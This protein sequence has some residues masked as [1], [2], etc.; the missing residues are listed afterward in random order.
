MT[1][2]LIPVIASRIR[3]LLLAVDTGSL[4]FISRYNYDIRGLTTALTAHN[5]AQFRRVS[6]LVLCLRPSESHRGG[7]LPIALPLAFGRQRFNPRPTARLAPRLWLPTLSLTRSLS[8]F[9]LNLCRSGEGQAWSTRNR[10]YS[11]LPVPPNVTCV[12]A[13]SVRPG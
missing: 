12:H 10:V 9:F 11:E 8:M 6:C 3:Y 4:P 5:Q 13:A 2:V 7:A 1:T